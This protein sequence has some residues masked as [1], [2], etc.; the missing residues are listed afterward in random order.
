VTQSEQNALVR[1]RAAEPASTSPSSAATQIDVHHRSGHRKPPYDPERQHAASTTRR[2][3]MQDLTRGLGSL[4]GRQQELEYVLGLL[5]TARLVTL[6]GAGGVG[7]TRL[8]AAVAGACSTNYPHGVRLAFLGSI[9]HPGLVPQAVAGA[10]GVPDESIETSIYIRV[11]ACG[12][13]IGTLLYTMLF[14]ALAGTGVHRAYA[15]V[16]LPNSAS[17]ALHRRFGFHEIGVQNEVGHK[18]GRY[19]SVQLFERHIN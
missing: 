4:V 12:R 3:M 17:V 13:G 1:A 2:P 15:Q 9:T 11:E 16:T 19:W 18:F 7:K 10:I 6:T 5:Q 8:A 14:G